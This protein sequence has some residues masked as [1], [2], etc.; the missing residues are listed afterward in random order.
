M[1]VCFS[2][3]VVSSFSERV[4]DSE[5]VTAM[6]GT[7]NDW[8]AEFCGS[9]P[10]RLKGIALLNVDQVE[11]GVKELERCA[12]MGL[13]GAM[14]PVSP[15]EGARYD[16]PMYDLLWAA[17]QDLEMP[18]NLHIGTPRPARGQ[19]FPEVDTMTPSFNSNQDHWVRMSLGDII[20]GGVFE[21]YPKL[22][23]GAV[24]FELS[25]TTYFLDR[26]DYTYT[27]R[28]RREGWYRFKEDMIPSDY[29][30]R[31][32]FVSFQEDA[33]GIRDRHDIGVDNLMWGSDY[34]HQESTFPRSRQILEEILGD[35][36]D[37]ERAKIA[38]GNAARVYNL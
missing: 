36:T 28:A 27:Q 1:L 18:L 13:A 19:G 24:E 38:G 34:P 25:W 7:Y 14:I 6:F 11:V 29:F 12:E 35:C 23:M 21:R 3:P 37:E 32:V 31:N 10:D 17:A 5:L 20:F 8:V 15:P 2:R 22:Q 30:H 16:S 4:P 26:I 33:R 9:F